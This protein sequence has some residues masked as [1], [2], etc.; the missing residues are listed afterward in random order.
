MIRSLDNLFRVQ[1][2]VCSDFERKGN[3]DLDEARLWLTKASL[4]FILLTLV[5][6]IIS[7]SVGY[8]LGF[9]QSLRLIELILP[10]FLAL[11]G[12]A[13]QFAVGHHEKKVW[14]AL[15]HPQLLALLVKGPLFVFGCAIVAAIAA[16]G[17]T[18]RS[19]A[20]F[21][22]GMTV[23]ALAALLSLCLGLLAV[24]TTTIANRLFAQATVVGKET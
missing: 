19:T 2:L 24:S 22:N 5:F 21:G 18:N 11:I 7:P 17:W 9:E 13:T 4:V 12:G 10:V 3:M 15:G 20:G 6:F 16:F 23:D 1:P 8:P 14:V